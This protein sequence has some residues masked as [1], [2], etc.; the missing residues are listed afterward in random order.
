MKVIVWPRIGG[1]SG[2]W[3]CS[4]CKEPEVASN[5]RAFLW[6][7]ENQN[8][9]RIAKD[10]GLGVVVVL[11]AVNQATSCL[12]CLDMWHGI[13]VRSIF[14]VRGWPWL[15]IGEAAIDWDCVIIV[16]KLPVMFLGI[17]WSNGWRSWM[18]KK[19]VLPYTAHAR[20]LVVE[21]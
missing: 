17:I 8:K 20:L 21:G 4:F 7:Q 3:F 19:L 12:G 5:L 14:R 11:M 15:M 6:S 9:S 18:S 10:V 13:A 2:F 1:K 16:G